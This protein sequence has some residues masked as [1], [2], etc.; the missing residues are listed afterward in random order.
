M[1]GACL[2]R[3]PAR[4]LRRCGPPR[5]Q[6]AGL[7]TCVI[8]SFAGR[9]AIMRNSVISNPV[10]GSGAKARSRLPMIAVW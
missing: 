9:K 6:A 4:P 2:G 8:A 10:R 3:L 7:A 5:W 1:R